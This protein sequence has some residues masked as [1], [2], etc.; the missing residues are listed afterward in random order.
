MA[1]TG[2]VSGGLD[3]QIGQ[4]GV[5][6]GLMATTTIPNFTLPPE[7]SRLNLSRVVK[8]NDRRLIVVSRA[9][10]KCGKTHFACMAPDP[11]FYAGTEQG[12]EGVVD[13]IAEKYN[14]VIIKKDFIVPPNRKDKGLYEKVWDDFA[15]TWVKV[16]D[17]GKFKTV[18]LDNAGDLWELIRMARFGKLT[19]VRPE[20]YAPVTAEFEELM[21]Y[22]KQI[23]GL[24]AIYLHKL[25]K[26]YV[27][28][29]GTSNDRG[30]W[31]GSYV[32]RGCESMAY[33]AQVNIEHFRY[34]RNDN[35]RGFGIRVINSRVSGDCDGLELTDDQDGMGI[36]MCN[37][38][39]LA[40][41]LY[42]GTVEGDWA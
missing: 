38:A 29:K 31:N 17:S 32:P 30:D 16:C 25:K 28:A 5:S 3:H 21:N 40:M 42:P 8:N 13:K 10:D 27:K 12:D 34:L 39:G 24:N 9:H 26:E 14:R 7:L 20:Q 1:D 4:A 11:V 37:F 19:Q 18:V 41:A 6:K 15:N 22:P 33:L 23:R 2:K 36:D 35:R